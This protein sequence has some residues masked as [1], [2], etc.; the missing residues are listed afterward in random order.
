MLLVLLATNKHLATFCYTCHVWPHKSNGLFWLGNEDDT[1]PP[2]SM[3]HVQNMHM[4]THYHPQSYCIFALILVEIGTFNIFNRQAIPHQYARPKAS[5]SI[6]WAHPKS[7]NNQKRIIFWAKFVLSVFLRAQNRAFRCF[8]SCKKLCS[9]SCFLVLSLVHKIVLFGALPGA[10]NHIFW[11]SPSCQK[12]CSRS[13]FWCSPSCQKS[14]SRSCSLLQL[15][16]LCQSIQISMGP[17]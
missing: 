9:T 7:C 11:C 2:V 13:C 12:P 10:K 16:G 5:K 8:P 14:C 6:P 3:S 15:L 1:Q 17:S 4:C